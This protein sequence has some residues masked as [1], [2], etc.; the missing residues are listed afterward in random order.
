MGSRG[1]EA[2]GEKSM[3]PDAGPA[4][5]YAH[6]RVAEHAVLSRATKPH[7]GGPPPRSAEVTRGVMPGR[8]EFRRNPP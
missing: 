6:G 8:P 1:L 3:R 4:G 2:D 7:A 5:L